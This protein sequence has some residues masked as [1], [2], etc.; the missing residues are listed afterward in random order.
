M[1]LQDLAGSRP[2]REKAPP[3]FFYMMETLL[4]M[5]WRTLQML[6]MEF[7]LVV[8][9]MIMLM[10]IPLKVLTTKMWPI[11]LLKNIQNATGPMLL[12]AISM[13]WSRYHAQLMVVTGFSIM[14][15]RVYL[16]QRMDM[17]IIFRKN[18]A[19]IIQTHHLA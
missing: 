15:V 10:M 19:S 1:N 17:R 9:K 16:R 14:Y 2:A 12:N 7:I 4:V 18:A 13:I 8:K 11:K 5:M 6:L 3:P